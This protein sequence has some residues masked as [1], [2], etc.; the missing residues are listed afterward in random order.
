MRAPLN[1]NL[2]RTLSSPI[3]EAASWLRTAP[4]DPALP[5]LNVSQAAP[6]APPPEP[7]RQAMAEAILT[8]T[9]A[10]L[11][12]PVL[13]LP[14]LRQA[15]AD[16]TG[17]LYGG[18][19]GFDQTG[20]TS[21]CNEAFT[22]VMTTL[23]QAGDEVIFPVPWYFN[24]AMWAD[25]SG[26]RPVALPTGPDLLPDPEHAESLITAKTRAI[27]LITPNNPSGAEYPPALIEAF[28]KLCQKRKIALVL[29]ETYRDFHSQDGA[30]HGLFQ[31]P[32]WDQTLIHLYSFSKAFRL[33]GH[34][35]GAVITNPE[36]LKQVEKY[37]DTVTIC[38]T[39]LGQIGALYGLTHLTDWLA[40][41][42]AEIL[43]RRAAV[44]REAQD[45]P[46]WDLLGCGAYFA[47]FKHPH[48]ISS[49]EL[50][51]LLVSQAQ[52]LLLPA[53]FFYPASDP[54]GAFETRIAFANI[55]PE[56]ITNLFARLRHLAL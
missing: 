10:H 15:L 7:L 36:R 35:V 21:G 51:P 19:V 24:H 50:A 29:D 26:V 33:T 30:P 52:I 14:E 18:A 34:R 48:P 22:A 9:E 1:P 43:R 23:A 16:H 40:Q 42:R 6:I 39:P 49:A 3:V 4:Q 5:L 56:Q 46:S 31:D 8:R 44:L 47:Y 13:G 53:T 11:Y 12:G 20:I 28:Y 32:D 45:L 37:L 38:A 25:M 27:V 17:R 54:R 55:T 2:A 41:E